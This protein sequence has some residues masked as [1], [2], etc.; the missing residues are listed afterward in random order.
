MPKGSQA[1]SEASEKEKEIMEEQARKSCDGC[2]DE[3]DC[4]KDCAKA[5][6]DIALGQKGEKR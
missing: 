1:I 2:P 5:W 6:R 3:Y 4:C